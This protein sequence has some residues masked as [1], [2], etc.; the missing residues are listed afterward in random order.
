VA[1]HFR[2][3]SR[4]C[5]I[6]P[7][8]AGKVGNSSHDQDCGCPTRQFYVWESSCLIRRHRRVVH[9]IPREFFPDGAIRSNHAN[10]AIHSKGKCLGCPILHALAGRVGNSSGS[11]DR[12]VPARRFYVWESSLN[13]PAQPATSPIPATRESPPPLPQRAAESRESPPQE[14]PSKTAVGLTE[15]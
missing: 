7:A 14:P 10:V 2:E 5:P 3:K 8:L 15:S 11:W 12:E 4:G 13:P 6:F 9:T 1:I